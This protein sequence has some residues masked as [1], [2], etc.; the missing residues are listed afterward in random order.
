MLL[1]FF[2]LLPINIF[3]LLL[4][5]PMAKPHYPKFDIKMTGLPD[6]CS[7]QQQWEHN[8]GLDMNHRLAAKTAYST[9][10]AEGPNQR[11]A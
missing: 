10:L 8:T 7:K 1:N 4:G 9:Q 2:S 11:Q 6:E 5:D 3:R